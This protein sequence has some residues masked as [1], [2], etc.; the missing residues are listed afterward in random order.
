MSELQGDGDQTAT[1]R[2]AACYVSCRVVEAKGWVGAPPR[3]LLTLEPFGP[4]PLDAGAFGLLP[5][6]ALWQPPKQPPKVPADKADLEGVG[7]LMQKGME[8][9]LVAALCL[10]GAAACIGQAA[11]A[12][13]AQWSQ[14]FKLLEESRCVGGGV[15]GCWGDR[16]CC[17]CVPVVWAIAGA[18]GSRPSGHHHHPAR[19][20][21]E[22][23]RQPIPR[24][25]HQLRS[26]PASPPRHA[27]TPHPAPRPDPCACHPGLST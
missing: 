9:P 2:A 13:G 19:E 24:R 17:V 20:L 22:P 27:H 10:G 4:P 3:P 6:M 11:L 23:S 15:L 18:A 25:A 16:V 8:S 12:G 21:A 7:N 5:F 1:R 26:P 14:Y